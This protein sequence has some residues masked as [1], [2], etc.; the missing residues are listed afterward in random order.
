MPHGLNGCGKGLAING[1]LPFI[2]LIE[3]LTT[4]TEVKTH[5]QLTSA[6]F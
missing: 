5:T 2:L 1:I 4:L 3:H 6:E